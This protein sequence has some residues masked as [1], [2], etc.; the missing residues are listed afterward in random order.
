MPARVKRLLRGRRVGLL[1]RVTVRG[2]L[3]VEVWSAAAAATARATTAASAVAT[4]SPP[5]LE[6]PSS[7]APSAARFLTRSNLRCLN[8]GNRTSAT[9]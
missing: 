3:E 6:I 8:S 7:A 5:S 2:R 1:H 9:H 4:T